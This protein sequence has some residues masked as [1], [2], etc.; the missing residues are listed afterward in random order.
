LNNFLQFIAC[1]ADGEPL[2]IQEITDA[3][4]HQD[5]MM[6]VIPSIASTLHGLELRELL[7]PI[8]QHVGLD[9]T[10]ITDFTNGEVAFGWNRWERGLHES[11]QSE[12]GKTEVTRSSSRKVVYRQKIPKLKQSITFLQLVF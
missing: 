3:S 2:F 4:N 8:T 12:K 6:L 1:T 11:G 7:L 5:F 9:A 10:Q